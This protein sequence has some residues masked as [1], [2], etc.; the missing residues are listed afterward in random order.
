[1][2][3]VQASDLDVRAALLVAARAELADRGHAAISLRAVARRAGVS[4]AAPKYYF[5]DRAALL[6]AVA[7]EGFHALAAALRPVRSSLAA[8][9]QAYIDFGLAHRALFDLM[10]R[11]TELHTGDPD[12]V[13]AQQAAIGAL[14]SAVAIA[15]GQAD[16]APPA[17]PDLTLIC[18]ALVH[19]LVVLTRDGALQSAT[20]NQHRTGP[21]L[22]H[23]LAAAFTTRLTE[24]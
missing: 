11:P 3:S 2:T 17:S 15:E 13:H 16:P 18:W 8:F 1:M 21:E 12:L 10:F 22:A 20:Q 24:Q 4:H 23:H 5:A 6:T 19:G 14:N 7:A 9:G